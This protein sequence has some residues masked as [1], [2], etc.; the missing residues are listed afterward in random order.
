MP[1]LDKT[2]DLGYIS[3]DK[4]GLIQIS[5]QL[6]EHERLGIK[7]SMRIKLE[8]NHQPYMEYH[9]EVIFHQ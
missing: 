1:N 4:K 7:E 9:R 8:K 6:E 5:N 2:F 3:F